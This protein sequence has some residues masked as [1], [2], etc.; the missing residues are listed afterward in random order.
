MSRH[1]VI[2]DGYHLRHGD[3]RGFASAFRARGVRPVTVMS[4]P[5]PLQKFVRKSIWY[6]DDFDAVHFYDGDFAKLLDIVG[7]YDPVCIVAGNERGVELTAA[8]VETLMPE[9]GNVPGSALAQRDKGEMARALNRNGV[10]GPETISTADPAQVA[11]WIQA[12]GLTGKRLI[13][14]PP[15]S[16]GTDNVHLVEPGGDWRQHFDKILGTVNGFDITNDTVIVQE[17]LQGPEYIV[18]L[19]SVDGR[20]GTVD[21]CVYTKHDRG[22]RIGIYD[23]ADFL[24]PGHPDVAV[25][26]DY[27]SRAANAVGIRNG[28]TH[29][30]VIMTQEGPRLVELAARYS[31]SCMMLSGL[32]ATGDNQIERTV[33]HALDSTFT[34]SFQFIRK[35]RTVW[36]CNDHGGPVRD[37][38]VLESISAL[39]TVD[40]MSIPPDG[41]WMPMTNDVTTSLGWIIQGAHSMDAIEADY[42][43]V[44]ELERKWNDLQSTG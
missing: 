31:G 24:P 33:R 36:L 2:V 10:P 35:V 20:H 22:S 18:D 15:K 5:R 21:T 1:A 38:Q 13:V 27:V 42:R 37:M 40:S 3:N 26:A 23:T 8:L 17:Y 41:T 6:P 30:E 9:S 11:N 39:A 4:T 28:S 19:Y 32:L 29:A 44:R 7:G 16:A 34:P 14:K 43:A 12:N 25:L